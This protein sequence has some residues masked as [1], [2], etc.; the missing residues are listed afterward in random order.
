MKKEKKQ[1]FSL[2]FLCNYDCTFY[3]DDNSTISNK[4]IKFHV[5]SFIITDKIYRRYK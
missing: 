4:L 5:K 2:F 1:D 3:F